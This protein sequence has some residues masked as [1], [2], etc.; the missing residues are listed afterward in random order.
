VHIVRDKGTERPG[1]Y[2]ASS[3][4]KEGTY[5]CRACGHALFRA[6]SQF[7]SG[8]GWPSFDDE[9]S[10]AIDRVLDRDG[11]RMEI[12]CNEC[13]AHL[14]HVF[15]G[16]YFTAKNLRHCVNSL[17]IEFVKSATVM[18][19]DEAIVAG[20]CFWGVQHLMQ[21]LPGVLLTE[22]GYTDG[23]KADPTYE[24]V[25][26]DQTGH[27]EVVR[28]VF[29]TAI[30]SYEKIL[31]YFFEIHDPVQPDGQ[32]PDVGSQY[33][34]RVF[35]F[36][37]KQQEIALSLISILSQKGYR[38]ATQVKPVSIFWP[39]EKYHQHYYSNHQSLPYCHRY[40]KKF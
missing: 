17:A 25:C 30:I 26:R 18:Q 13:K 31:S 3:V 11:Q 4:V 28:I 35:Y 19:T 27:V 21:Q 6:D 8:C 22:V 37:Q 38:I 36:D 23:F 9:I 20:G 5:L 14:G 7:S 12:C 24:A 15:S 29:D 10:G 39:A 40:E 16:E 34:S 33:L 32:G 2:D 1:T